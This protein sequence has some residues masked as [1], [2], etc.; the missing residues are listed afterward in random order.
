MGHIIFLDPLAIIGCPRYLEGEYYSFKLDIKITLAISD[1]RLFVYQGRGKQTERGFL[2][3]DLLVSED[4]LL[5]R[6][7]IIP[8]GEIQHVAVG[9]HDE[10]NIVFE[11]IN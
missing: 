9:V 4:A 8:D 5:K 6:V 1:G 3:Q 2:E 10:L 11:R 7:K